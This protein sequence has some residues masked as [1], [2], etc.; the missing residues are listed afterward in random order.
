MRLLEIIFSYGWPRI[1]AFTALLIGIV[2]ALDWKL[3]PHASLGLLYLF[4]LFLA[5]T[6]LSRWQIVALSA[7]LTALKEVFG[8]Y[9][10]HLAAD[11]M[12]TSLA[13]YIAA[14][15]FIHELVKNWRIT[16]E[17][18]REIDK[19]DRLV[20][21]SE[22]QL[23][24]LIETSSAAI[25]T[26]DGSG[27]VIQANA[28]ANKLLGIESG[29]IGMDVSEYLPTVG[30]LAAS[31]N[32]TVL[33][34]MMDCTGRRS[35]GEAFAASVSFSNYQFLGSPRLTAIVTEN[36]EPVTASPRMPQSMSTLSALEQD[37]LQAILEGKTNKEIAGTLQ[38]TESS[39]KNAIQRL[40][41]KMGSRTRSQLVRAAIEGF[42]GNRK[43]AAHGK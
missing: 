32:G 40:F 13:S 22:E 43:I 29:L 1:M 11:R 41:A 15:W 3:F 18:M 20:R 35:S 16:K 36:E 19:R 8:P 37:V 4:P 10:S 5:A 38:I 30:R 23:R 34:T 12:L 9:S 33:R 21:E 7:F 39:V 28:A 27:K 31:N 2:S 17:H 14:G 24:I 25:L 42:S 26:L 6:R